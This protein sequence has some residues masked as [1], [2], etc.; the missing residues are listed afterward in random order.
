LGVVTVWS[1]RRVAAFAVARVVQREQHFRGE[2]AA[3]FQHLVDDVGIDFRVFRQR[4]Q[5]VFHFQQL[6]QNELHIPD[7]RDVLT[8]DFLLMTTLV[9]E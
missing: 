1:R 3:F 9:F 5:F 6:V 8:H 7:W 4:L 2:L